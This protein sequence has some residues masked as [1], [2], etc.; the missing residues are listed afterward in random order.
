MT[1][2]PASVASRRHRRRSPGASGSPRRSP[3]AARMSNRRPAGGA[4]PGTAKRP[5]EPS[6]AGDRV[7][8]I[9]HRSCARV[10]RS[11]GAART[12]ASV[13]RV[14]AGRRRAPPR[15]APRARGPRCHGSWRRV[16]GIPVRP[17]RPADRARA[18]PRPRRAP[19]GSPHHPLVRRRGRRQV[20][21]SVKEP[22][23]DRE[24]NGRASA[25]I[26]PSSRGLLQE[27][28]RGVSAGTSCA[29]WL[30]EADSFR[31]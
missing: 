19:Y 9:D 21:R 3:R 6:E 4:T 13:V 20:A 15:T 27:G 25:G 18:P 1:I 23:G 26:Q 8:G 2:L 10:P 5:S 12:Q 22:W 30:F 17:R 28:S 29:R 16:H 14:R 7:A 24:A 11:A 31:D